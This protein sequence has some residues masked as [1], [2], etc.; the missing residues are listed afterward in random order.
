MAGR[1]SRPKRTGASR[2]IALA[3]T[4]A[5]FFVLCTAIAARPWKEKAPRDPRL[6]PLAARE[7]HLAHQSV[8]V[9]RLVKRRWLVYERRLRH[10]R[11]EIAAARK[12]HEEELAAAAAA[13]RAA[14]A[15]AS[16]ASQSSSYSGSYV[17]SA[18]SSGYAA[19]A[20]PRVVTLA[21][22][23]RVVSLPPVTTSAPS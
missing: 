3:L 6:A 11:T 15:A 19:P 23:V 12:K 9:R 10:R 13:A 7:R 21:P 4:L 8:L 18:P 22:Q 14:A 1:Q 5:V 2:F 16:L 20:A 17:S